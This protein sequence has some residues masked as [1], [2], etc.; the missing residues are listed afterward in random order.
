MS[1]A[2]AAVDDDTPAPADDPVLDLWE[3]IQIITDDPTDVGALPQA[4]P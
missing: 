3:L 2:T 1:A 4:A